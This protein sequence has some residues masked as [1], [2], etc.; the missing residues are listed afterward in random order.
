MGAPELEYIFETVVREGT[1]IGTTAEIIQF[2]SDNGANTFNVVSKTIQTSNGSSG[3]ILVNAYTAIVGAVTSAVS[4]GSA[5]I[6]LEVGTLGLAVAPALGITTGLL[7]YNLAPD[8]WTNLDLAIYDL[9]YTIGRKVVAFV[10]DDGTLLVPEDVINAY[11]NAFIDAGLY[12]DANNKTT[13][14][15]PIT[16]Y[17]PYYIY[18][19]ELSILTSVSGHYLAIGHYDQSDETFFINCVGDAKAMV[20]RTEYD[21]PTPFFRDSLY[22]VGTNGGAFFTLTGTNSIG[23]PLAYNFFIDLVNGFYNPIGDVFVDPIDLTIGGE[24]Y[25]GYYTDLYGEVPGDSIY[26]GTYSGKIYYDGI[27]NMLNVLN[28]VGN[29]IF[30]NKDIEEKDNDIVVP[31]VVYPSP[32]EPVT[33]TYPDWF[34]IV[35]PFTYPAIIPFNYPIILPLQYP[36]VDAEIDPEGARRPAPDIGTGTRRAIDD[37]PEIGEGARR[38]HEDPDPTPEPDPI[39]PDIGDGARRPDPPEPDPPIPPTPVIPDPTPTTLSSNKLFTVYNP[40]DSELNSL[41]AY[42]WDSSL[43]ETL[44]KIWQN[45]LDGIISLIQ[46][47]AT[48]TISSNT[49]HIILGYL[50]SNV[51][52]HTVTSQFVTLDCGSVTLN[53][54]NQNVGDY[55]PYTSLHVF[56]PFIGI[57]ELDV[58][59]C[60]RGTINIKYR[61][62]VYTGTCLAVINV[63]R[64]GDLPNGGTIYQFTGNCS[65]QIPLTSGSANGLLN[66]LVTGIGACVAVGAGGGSGAVMGGGAMLSALSKEMVHVSHSGNMGANAGILGNKKPY[67]IIGRAKPYNATEYSKYIGYPSNKTVYVGN[68]SGFIKCKADRFISI[69]TDEE[70]TEIISLLHGGVIV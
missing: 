27:H 3:N 54:V 49:Q 59:E 30:N 29:F 70:M 42:L 61:I 67:L 46:I 10:K 44:K 7:M 52:A 38:P 8:F 51:D 36:D 17:E 13:G 9:G 50:D 22:L 4:A 60:M 63:T 53:E 34:P 25:K 28:D 41:G 56:L 16:P 37:K 64:S 47:Y 62:D 69:A 32:D 66:T 15:D 68:C 18:D 20:I 58:N 19:T 6:G 55:I 31:D 48:P 35:I 40:S 12:E 24:S 33:T 11:K 14:F 2:P 21:E 43:I 23:R 45:P 39:I 1:E 26:T 5:L 57:V 65:Q